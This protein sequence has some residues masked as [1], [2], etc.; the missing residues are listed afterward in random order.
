MAKVFQR[1]KSQKV[2]RSFFNL[3]YEKLFTCDMGQLIPVMHDE[4]VPGDIFKIGNTAVV[5]FNPLVAPILHEINMYVHYFFVPYR[6]LWEDFEDFITGG[7]DGS[8]EPSLPLWTPSGTSVGSLW[9]YF[10]FPTGVIPSGILPV[11][12]PK[13]AYN[14]IWNEYY[15]DETLQN[16]VDIA[17]S[18]SILYRN[19]HKDYFTSALPWQQRGV[20][21]ALPI[22]G[23]TKAIWP[24]GSFNVSAPTTSIGGYGGAQD[25]R[26]Y[27]NNSTVL[28]NFKQALE[29]NTVDLSSASP[30]SI[31]DLR[32]AFQVQR[33]LERNA[34]AGARYTE[35]LRSHFGVAPRDE[36]LDRPEYIG[37][38]KAPVI[39]SEVLQTSESNTTP[40][41]N[42]AGHGL[43]VNVGYAGTY[44]VQEFGIIIAL[45]SVMP[46]A[47]YSQ[48]VDRQWIKSSR[49][50]FV[51]PEF[52][53]LSEQPIYRGEIYANG[54]KNDN[55]T[56][57]GFQG[58]YDEHRV[59]KNLYCGKMRTTFNYWH[60]GRIF[61]S[62]P[63]L[64]S[65]FIKCN[66]DKRIFAV[67]TEPGL[68]VQ[69]ANIIKAFRPLPVI[70][71]P[72]LIDHV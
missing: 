54:V 47:V 62:A 66:P 9:D 44:K 19:W 34:Q 52:V 48:G 58:R 21:P 60:L 37:G 12:F 6:L 53:N 59:K 41:A 11:D 72:G 4:V 22:I 42:M 32:L 67:Q 65:D 3:S 10:G 57:F 51:F 30:L 16:K 63:S 36:R 29:T 40:L 13:R 31:S 33:W 55:L 17:N 61:A 14:L 8:L 64:N 71:T 45:M 38:T 68:I 7:A 69:F 46:R 43:G 26:F 23:T 49:Y 25:Y 1:V 39:I 5:R 50:D 27:A 24:S 35:F 20:S 15:R 2:R 70:P 56:I 18:E 28:N